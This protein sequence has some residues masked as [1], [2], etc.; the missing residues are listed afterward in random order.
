[1][2]DDRGEDA[3]ALSAFEAE[4]HSRYDRGADEGRVSRHKPDQ[5]PVIRAGQR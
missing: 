5:L 2:C 1:M 3:T 4:E